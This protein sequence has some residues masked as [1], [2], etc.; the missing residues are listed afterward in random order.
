MLPVALCGVHHGQ[1]VLPL[2]AELVLSG[3]KVPLKC[4]DTAYVEPDV[5]LQD[6]K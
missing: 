3:L 6:A 1:P 4:V 5:L 2:D